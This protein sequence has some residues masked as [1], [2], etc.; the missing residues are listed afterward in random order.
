MERI[1][2][3]DRDSAG[4]GVAG[5]SFRGGTVK[6]KI[7]DKAAHRLDVYPKYG[8]PPVPFTL[9]GS[10]WLRFTAW[11]LRYMVTWNDYRASIYDKDDNLIGESR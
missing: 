8:G 6:I 5:I 10:G 9:R 7:V 4:A 11:M 3:P 1:N 2:R